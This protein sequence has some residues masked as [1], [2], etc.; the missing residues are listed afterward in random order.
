MYDM[1]TRICKKC[2]EEKP[3]SE[4]YF[5][6]D[7]NDYRNECKICHNIINRERYNRSSE[8]DAEK[9]RERDRRYRKEHHEECNAKQRIRSNR[10]R[11]KHHDE[12]NKSR[13][14]KY[15]L[16][17]D[18]MHAYQRQKY[19]ENIEQSRARANRYGEKHRE[20]IR[21]RMRDR[22]YRDISKSREDRRI[23][24]NAHKESERLINRRAD[25]K[26][27][28]SLS[29]VYVARAINI[30]TGVDVRTIYKYP[31]LIEVKR[32]QIKLLRLTKQLSQ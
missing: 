5:R 13:R 8:E 29:D 17:I 19:Y 3:I 16:N 7:C 32:A 6:R 25:R 28:E 2:G 15:A 10:Y 21:A 1:E 11:Q 18:Y 22:Y 9:R 26:R 31:E 23:Y 27:S 14:E 24:Y 4:F 12:I 30:S 20:V